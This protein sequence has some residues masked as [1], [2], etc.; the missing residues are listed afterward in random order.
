M[1]RLFFFTVEAACGYSNRMSY[2]IEK[3]FYFYFAAVKNF[4]SA[5]CVPGATSPKLCELCKG[6]CSRTHN[7]PYYDYGGAFESV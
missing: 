4:F 3:S 5:S 6:D 1:V 7:E 2:Q